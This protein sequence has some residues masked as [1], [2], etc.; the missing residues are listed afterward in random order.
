[1]MNSFKNQFR[2]KLYYS[3]ILSYAYL[4]ILPLVMAIFFYV[5]SLSIVEEEI[6]KAGIAS[7]EQYESIMESMFKQIQGIGYELET[8][9]KISTIVNAKE[10]NNKLRYDIYQLIQSLGRY[11][12]NDYFIKSL[13]V[14]PK[15]HDILI[16]KSGV[17]NLDTYVEQALMSE[18]NSLVAWKNIFDQKTDSGFVTLPSKDNTSFISFLSPFHDTNKQVIGNVGVI[19]DHHKIKKM[20]NTTKWM[21]GSVAYVMSDTGETIVSSNGSIKMI[22]ND[23]DL[24]KDYFKQTINNNSYLVFTRQ[25]KVSGYYYVLTVP[26]KVFYVK[27]TRLRQMILLFTLICLIAGVTL[28]VWFSAKNYNPVQNILHIFREQDKNA[29]EGKDEIK[30]IEASIHKV[31]NEM[32][33]VESRI[34]KQTLQLRNQ[35]LRRLINGCYSHEIETHALLE[36]YDVRFEGDL[37]QIALIY[38]ESDDTLLED[39]GETASHDVLNYKM[40]LIEKLYKE[41][42][43][44]IANSYIVEMGKYFVVIMNNLDQE[45]TQED[46]RLKAKK[47]SLTIKEILSAKFGLFVSIALSDINKGIDQI[48]LSYDQAVNTMEYAL[49]F[50]RQEVTDYTSI[51]KMG[52]KIEKGFYTFDKERKLIS[53]IR[54]GEYHEGFAVLDMMLHQLLKSEVSVEYARCTVF[55]MVNTLSNIF[56]ELSQK[57]SQSWELELNEIMHAIMNCNSIEDIRKIMYRTFQEAEKNFKSNHS[58]DQKVKEICKFIKHNYQDYNLNVS[59]IA[60]VFQMNIAYLSSF[61]KSTMGV[62]ISKY[63]NNVRL[64]KAKILLKNDNITIKEIASMCGLGDSGTFIRVFKKVEGVT[65]GKYRKYM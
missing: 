3:L 31:I 34:E 13:F 59:M 9:F 12:G 46:I 14:Y 51:K 35:F 61:F 58:S 55:A 4:L 57:A 29:M 40:L 18:P 62:N 56:S 1:M 45:L 42:L 16:T 11:Y 60:N 49:L 54:S 19:I 44:D 23:W 50:G 52:C 30:Y 41:L 21:K 39:M 6:E 24:S 32:K 20:L 25:S 8:N 43:E 64:E 2:G 36:L 53:L 7:L 26:E 47:A 65:P 48:S 17:M 27:A 28:A 10:L 33:K 38:V 15:N 22:G 63:L 37:Y 5:T